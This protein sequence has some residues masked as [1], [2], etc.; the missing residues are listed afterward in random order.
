M[1]RRFSILL[2]AAL[3]SAVS[4]QEPPA[5][6]R[7]APVKQFIEKYFRTWS[8]VEMDAYADGFLPEATIQFIDPKGA[9]Q[10]QTAK[11]FLSEQRRYQSQRPAKESPLSI[12]IRFEEKLARAVVFWQLD[13][14]AGRSKTGYDHFTLIEQ[15][16]RWRIINLVF[17]EAPQKN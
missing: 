9:V 4:A 5:D 12:D 13:D 17:Y 6:P 15:N 14:S 7:L 8:N 1:L 3:C 11:V 10:T 16:G 2:C